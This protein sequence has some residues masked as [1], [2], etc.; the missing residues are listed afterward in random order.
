MIVVELKSNSQQFLNDRFN[1]VDYL[2][3]SV[4]LSKRKDPT[5]LLILG[6]GTQCKPYLD[7]DDLLNAMMLSRQNMKESINYLNVGVKEGTVVKR[8][9]E[10]VVGEMGLK[11]VTF[12]FSG[13][14]RGWS[15]DVPFYRYDLSRARKLGWKAKYTSQ[16]AVR[17]SGRE[18][19]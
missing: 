7:I 14:K 4:S 11:N 8:I 5:R 3:T 2:N 10:I 16:E 18:N 13:G 6:D 17:R 15:G 9:A 1:Y 12:E 19:L